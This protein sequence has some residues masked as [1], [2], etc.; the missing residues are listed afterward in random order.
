MRCP[1][2]GFEQ[3]EDIFCANCGIEVAVYAANFQKKRKKMRRVYITAGALL[4]VILV[5]ILMVKGGKHSEESNPLSAEDTTVVTPSEKEPGTE[6]AQTAPQN[7]NE[8]LKSVKPHET[9]VSTAPQKIAPAKVTE[10]TLS[11][12]KSIARISAGGLSF[13]RDEVRIS[14]I[15]DGRLRDVPFQIDSGWDIAR[16]TPFKKDDA[17]LVRAMDS[18]PRDDALAAPLGGRL[19]WVAE[20]AD[21]QGGKGWFYIY[22]GRGQ[23]IE[24]KGGPVRFS[25]APEGASTEIYTAAFNDSYHAILG[26]LILGN[27]ELIDREKIRLTYNKIAIDESS[28]TARPKVTVSGTF[29]SR[30]RWEGAM[31][32]DDY[33]I[34]FAQETTFYPDR[35]EIWYSFDFP[36]DMVKAANLSVYLDLSRSLTGYR[37]MTSDLADG[38]QITGNGG[39]SEHQGK[40]F[41]IAGGGKALRVTLSGGAGKLILIDDVSTDDAPDSEPGCF[42]CS[43][44]EFDGV[45]G[46]LKIGFTF[47]AFNYKI[48]DPLPPAFSDLMANISP[49][50]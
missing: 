16:S 7:E 33:E 42:G 15:K 6:P 12:S 4:A 18:G 45:R 8:T 5:L 26:S 41:V 21:T 43:G 29:L 14:A 31:A 39:A 40:W 23:Q 34:P 30:S 32:N 49:L 27:T 10:T 2:C 17:I 13:N 38:K 19:A 24:G 28:V 3:P 22:Q 46:T 35:F 48:G 25:R 47:E 50:Q 9:P 11:N 44:F 37:V 1:K 20:V 36:K